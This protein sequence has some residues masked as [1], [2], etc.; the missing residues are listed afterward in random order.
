LIGSLSGRL[1]RNSLLGLCLWW[2]VILPA[3]PFAAPLVSIVIDDL[4]HNPREDRRAIALPA[5]VA[6]A[7]LPHT[8]RSNALANEAHG[9]GKEVLL[10]LPM[11]P[12][13]DSHV[14]AGP[15]RIESHMSAREITAM[16]AYDL[17]TVPHAVGVNNHMGSRVTQNAASM[18]ALMR[19]IRARGNL[20]F[21]DS[22]TSPSSVAAR[23]AEETGVPTLRRDV[24]LDNDR[25]AQAVSESLQQL[26]RLLVTRGRAIAIGHPYPETLTALERWL[27]QARARGIRIVPLSVLLKN[28][29]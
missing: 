11:D 4:G 7:I 8:D 3:Q 15:G 10:H 2:P 28:K 19:A 18:K 29:N 17:Q 9:A 26:E 27:P 24:F 22:L 20:F 12:E 5:P 13:N 16:F 6:V 21:L 14:H 1:L 23:I 25:S